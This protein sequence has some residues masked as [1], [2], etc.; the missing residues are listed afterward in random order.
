M[1]KLIL[2]S[3]LVFAIAGTAT[4]QIHKTNIAAGQEQPQTKHAGK[5]H[6]GKKH[7]GKKHHHKHQHLKK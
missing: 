4:T 3:F 6:A 5:K 2:G 7:A 1:K